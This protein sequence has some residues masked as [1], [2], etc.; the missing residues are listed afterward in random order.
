MY[1]PLA[2]YINTF[3]R[4]LRENFK[5]CILYAEKIIEIIIIFLNTTFFSLGFCNNIET[6]ISTMQFYIFLKSKESFKPRIH[7]PHYIYIRTLLKKI[8][9]IAY[10]I[11]KNI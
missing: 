8:Y 6:E 3:E 1:L 4:R 5:I 7:R 10:L 2:V 9:F 11:V